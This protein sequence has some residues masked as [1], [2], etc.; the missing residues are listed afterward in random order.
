MG[1]AAMVK[2]TSPKSLSLSVYKSANKRSLFKINIIL[3]S[4]CDFFQSVALKI[5]LFFTVVS[6][7]GL[8]KIYSFFI[9][10][11][12]KQNR[13]HKKSKTLKIH[14]NKTIPPNTVQQSG[15]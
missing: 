15:N 14:S 7:N 8:Q 9:R 11:F 2:S 12:E 10:H 6:E 4:L 3:I 5:T 13:P 1:P